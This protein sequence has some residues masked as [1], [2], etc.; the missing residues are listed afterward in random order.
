MQDT[1]AATLYER[2][3]I[4]RR[5]TRSAI[6]PPTSARTTPGS[7]KAIS[8][9]A[10][11]PARTSAATRSRTKSGTVTDWIPTPV[12]AITDAIHQRA[13]PGASSG[14]RD[15]AG[16]GLAGDGSGHALIGPPGGARAW[17]APEPRHN[18]A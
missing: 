2:T 11:A 16:G 14:L 18:A 5:S 8:A 1:S 9:A 7:V 3:R 13:K 15:S 4:R 12:P 6:A 17:D 10:I